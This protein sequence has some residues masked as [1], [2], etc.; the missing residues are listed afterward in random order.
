MNG[1]SIHFSF[2]SFRLKENFDLINANIL[3]SFFYKLKIPK[4][5]NIYCN[6]IHISKNTRVLLYNKITNSV[7]TLTVSIS[8]KCDFHSTDEKHCDHAKTRCSID[9]FEA[10]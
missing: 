6:H 7:H 2:K 10:E 4:G 1:V 3:Y 5:Q 8:E 9:N